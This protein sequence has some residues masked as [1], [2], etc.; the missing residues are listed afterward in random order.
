MAVLKVLKWLWTALYFLLSVIVVLAVA[1]FAIQILF[2][3][4]PA[5]LR[6]AYAWT[7]GLAVFAQVAVVIALVIVVLPI[8]VVAFMTAPALLRRQ[9]QLVVLAI[10][11]HFEP[12]WRVLVAPFR[13]GRARD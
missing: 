12:L 13:S 2:A 6:H 4:V 7:D 1:G 5:A 3:L 11:L 10:T 8:L 9:L